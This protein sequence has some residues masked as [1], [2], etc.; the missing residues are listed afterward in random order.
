[1][2]TEDF[3]LFAPV[4]GFGV[5]AYVDGAKVSG[6]FFEEGEEVNGVITDKP[7]FHTALAP[8]KTVKRHSTV[9]I[10]NVTYK[11]LA[12]IKD[13]LGMVILPLEEQ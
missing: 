10:N 9:V 11:S 2:F 6:N 3:S 1:M 5:T 4:T 7:E 13:G 8:I 12:P